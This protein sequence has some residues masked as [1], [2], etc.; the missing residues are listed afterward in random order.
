MTVYQALIPHI[1]NKRRVHRQSRCKS[2]DSYK[3]NVAM[4]YATKKSQYSETKYFNLRAGYGSRTRLLG[5]GSQCTTDV[6]IPQ[7]ICFV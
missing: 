1:H 5:L 4:D 2:V 3:K 6:L 7:Y